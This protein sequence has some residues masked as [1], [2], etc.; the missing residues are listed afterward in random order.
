MPP[1]N[2][3]YVP[4]L[5]VRA[6]EM[7][8]MEYLP[9]VSKDKMEPLFLLAPWANSK[10]LERTI[11]RIERAFR[12]RRYFLDVDRDY[13]PTNPDNPAQL[14]W[15]EL[16]NSTDFFKAWRDFWLEHPMV[17]PCLQLDGQNEEDIESQIRLTQEQDREFCLRIELRR[18][19][20]NLRSAVGVLAK[21]G[22]AD[23]SIIIEGGWVEEPLSMYAAVHGL[24]TGI[25]AGLDGRI[26]IVV[27]CTSMIR[28]FSDIEGI[29][30]IRF[31]NHQLLN[32]LR[33]S[34]NRDRLLY[35][36]GAARGLGTIALVRRRPQESIT[37]RMNFGISR[38][39]EERNGIIK[40]LRTSY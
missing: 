23:Y 6:S 2:G 28:G 24:V 27:S 18:M 19:P 21:L 15:L 26:P 36:I 29:G 25:L 30:Q 4:T 5:A 9:G 7:N 33:R 8:G 38:G 10:A 17:V 16:R 12:D 1:S 13:L 34:T 11:E 37:L 14:K 22:T 3:I 20:I 31:S 32:D 35:E 40:R 39:T